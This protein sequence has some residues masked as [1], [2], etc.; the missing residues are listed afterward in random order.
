[1]LEK[2]LKELGFDEKEAMVYIALLELGPSPVA[3]IAKKT[4]IKRTGIYYDL[5]NL[6][7]KGYISET[8]ENKKKK[9]IAEEPERIKKIFQQ[10]VE[11][12]NQIIPDLTNLATTNLSKPSVRYFVGK[13][14]LKIMFLDS[15]ELP[16]K[17]EILAFVSDEPEKF[18][19]EFIKTYRAKRIKKKIIYKGIIKESK[20][21]KELKRHAKKLYFEFKLIPANIFDP[22]LEINIYG[23]KIVFASFEYELLGVMIE[24][25]IIA[26]TMRQIFNLVW[27]KY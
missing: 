13:E 7:E 25:K 5:E 27:E 11:R 24:S 12:L 14:G 22:K 1:M 6:R 16:K 21:A 4:G 3:M 26:D 23:N 20:R 15:L 18:L 9:Y 19:P 17:S 8:V 10:R 2:E